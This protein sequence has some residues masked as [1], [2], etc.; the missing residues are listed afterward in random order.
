MPE[1]F[2]NP[3]GYSGPLVG[4]EIEAYESGYVTGSLGGEDDASPRSMC[5]V[6]RHLREAS[7]L[8]LRAVLNCDHDAPTSCALTKSGP[9]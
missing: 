6:A 9:P 8:P 2:K 1:V 3:G 7:G 4:F 5:R